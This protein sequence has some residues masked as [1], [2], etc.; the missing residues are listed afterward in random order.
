MHNYRK[1]VYATVNER[2]I[3]WTA[4]VIE[5]FATTGLVSV[6]GICIY[7]TRRA[8]ELENNFAKAHG[9]HLG[10]GK[11]RVSLTEADIDFGAFATHHD[12]ESLIKSE[13]LSPTI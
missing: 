5:S 8:T 1:V 13:P 6:I 11:R 2:W 10:P 4:K 9:L 7:E 3:R 12:H